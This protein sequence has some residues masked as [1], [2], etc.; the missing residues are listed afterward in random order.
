[1]S[2][3]TRHCHRLDFCAIARYCAGIA[4]AREDRDRTDA[5]TDAEAATRQQQAG[6]D[7][8]VR[9]NG[10]VRRGY[11]AMSAGD[12]T[13]VGDASRER[14]NAETGGAAASV[15]EIF[16]TRSPEKYQ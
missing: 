8:V 2:T 11:G 4:Y 9:E 6:V 5:D 10:D 7:N 13:R 1:M 14:G 16:E 3:A 15:R 12:G